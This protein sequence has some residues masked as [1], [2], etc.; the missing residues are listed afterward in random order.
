MLNGPDGREGHDRCGDAKLEAVSDQPEWSDDVDQADW[1]AGRIAPFGEGVVSVVPAGFEAYARILHPAW[2]YREDGE[3]ERGVR[4]REIAAWSGETIA[5]LSQFY[6]ISTPQEV[7]ADDPPYSDQPRK[8]SLDQK[9][10][11]AI[12]PILR[13]WTATPDNCRFCLWDGYGWDG[14]SP[15]EFP[16][17]KAVALRDPIERKVRQGTKVRLPDREYFL[18]TGPVESALLSSQVAPAEQMP[19]LWWP[20]DRAWCVG[21][22]LDLAWT[23]V[24]GSVGLIDQLLASNGLEVLSSDPRDPCFLIEPWLE[25]LVSNAVEELLET[26]ATTVITPKGTVTAML[27]RPGATSSGELR[28]RRHGRGGTAESRSVIG[29][30]S[31]EHLLGDARSNLRIQIIAL[32][33]T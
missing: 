32:V 25:R 13:D 27:E 22:E 19:N 5:P 17:Q 2:L 4:W 29:N 8:G 33:N 16:A 26:G 6:S 30:R 1:I 10:A 20:Q 24:G 12:I 31:E 23:Y 21:S 9:D 11:E 15:F 7:V 28:I 3:I 14:R 18:Y